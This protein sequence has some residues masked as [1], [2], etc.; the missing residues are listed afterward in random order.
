MIKQLREIIPHIAQ[1]KTYKEIA[2]LYSVSEPTIWRWV[3]KLR[4]GGF[5]V[6]S[7]KGRKPKEL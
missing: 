7:T 3:S 6:P 2:D 1:G 5:T 4:A